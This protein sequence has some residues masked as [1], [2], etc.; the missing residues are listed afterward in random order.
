[1]TL[2]QRLTQASSKKWL[3]IYLN[4]YTFKNKYPEIY[5]PCL[6]FK[7][8]STKPTCNGKEICTQIP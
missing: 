2:E 4:R 7:S 6:L 3:K 1:M 5:S 8:Q